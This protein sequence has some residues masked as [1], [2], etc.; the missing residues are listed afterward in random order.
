M[1]DEEVD[2]GMDDADMWR[3]GTVGGGLVEGDDDEDVLDLDGADVGT[4]AGPGAGVGGGAAS[5][6][7]VQGE[8]NVMLEPANAVLSYRNITAWNGHIN[9]V[10]LQHRAYPSDADGSGHRGHRHEADKNQKAGN[11][12]SL[13]G[14][15]APAPVAV[16]NQ[17]RQAA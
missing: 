4:G 7:G 14:D 12:Q 1:A 10:A 17:V 13:Q 8:W 6:N 16:E 2:W 5:G 9:L 11:G 15:K 3:N